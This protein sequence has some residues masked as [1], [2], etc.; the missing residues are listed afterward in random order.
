MKNLVISVALMLILGMPALA[1]VDQNYLGLYFDTLGD[2]N[3]LEV[4][5]VTPYVPMNL[6]LLLMNPDFDSLYG[7]EAG[8][9]IEGPVLI[10]SVDFA[11]DEALNVGTNDNMIV[12]YGV[13]QTTSQATLLATF[14]LLY[15][16]VSMEPVC[17]RLHGTTPSSI[18]PQYPTLL[19]ADGVLMMAGVDPGPYG[20]CTA[21]IGECVSATEECT[22]ESLKALYR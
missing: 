13:P 1:Q 14:S 3:C 12:G 17:F 5:T 18:D 7:F 11:V 9:T 19:L 22:F 16:S 2:Q 6:Y 20:D 21:M 8:L 15:S 4:S 10:L